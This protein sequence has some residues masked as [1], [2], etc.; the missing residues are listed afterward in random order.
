MHLYDPHAVCVCVRQEV[1]TSGGLHCVNKDIKLGKH[2]RMVHYI[3][4]P[5]SGQNAAN[6]VRMEG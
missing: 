1:R 4:S 6:I 3:K 5:L 2:R